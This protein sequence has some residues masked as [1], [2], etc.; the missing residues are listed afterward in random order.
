MRKLLTLIIIL[1]VSFNSFSQI[2]KV[3]T[4]KSETIGKIAPM[5]QTHIECS[6]SGDT[7][8]FIYSDI[9][10]QQITD[11]KSF[12]FKD[13]DNAFD[14]LYQTIMDG[15]KNP[16][17]E[18]I[19]LEL[20]NDMIFL[21]FEKNLGVTSFQFLHCPGKNPEIIGMSVYLTKKKVRKLFGMKKRERS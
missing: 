1:C 11:F 12:S 2:K 13:I 9:K 10:F 17:K 14:N 19:R 7:Y 16:P 5:G 20:P 6:K 18:D 4:E 15:M 21:H 8:T 3:K